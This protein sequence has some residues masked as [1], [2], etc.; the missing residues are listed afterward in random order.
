M[1]PELKT[2]YDRNLLERLLPRLVWLLF[3]QPKPMPAN[4]GQTVNFRRF[5]SLPVTTTALTEGVTPT[6]D[7][8]TITQITATPI[9]YGHWIEVTDLVVFTSF[10]PILTE[11]GTLLAE[12]AAQKLDIIVRNTVMAGTN[13]QYAAA[14]TARVQVAAGDNLKASEIRKAVRTMQINKVAKQTS[15]VNSGTGVGTKPI[16]AAYIGIVGPSALYDLKTDAAF[17]PV[18]QYGSATPLLPFEVGSLDE[19]RFVLSNNTT[20]YPGAGAAGIDVHATMIFGG[21]WFGVISPKGIENIIKPFGAGQDPL[22][23]RASTGWKAFFTAV[24]LNQ[25]AGI[26]IEH[27]VSA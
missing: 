20:L 6:S 14:H 23:Q 10:D 18:E 9:Q 16:A 11:F 27:A 17:V 7:D 2:Y 5:E 24:I 3:G 4:E 26:R 21:N 12:Q 19:V 25:V 13:V 8:V 1:A 22:N 15:I